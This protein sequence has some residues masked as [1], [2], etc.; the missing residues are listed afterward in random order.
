V[1]AETE[2][3]RAE[4]ETKLTEIKEEMAKQLEQ[5]SEKEIKDR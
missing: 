3:V 1:K 2:A 5:Q 4:F